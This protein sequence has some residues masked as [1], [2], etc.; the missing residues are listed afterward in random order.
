MSF[1]DFMSDFAQPE[2]KALAENVG[3]TF[4]AGH[5][6]VSVDYYGKIKNIEAIK[7]FLENIKEM[8]LYNRGWRFQFGTSKSWAGLCDA[9]EDQISKSKNKN[10]FIS[11]DFVKHDANWMKEMEGV[12][13]HEIAHAIVFEI[14]HF[15]KVSGIN[16]IDPEHNKTKGHG[17]IWSS[18]CGS[19]KG[20]EGG[21][22]RFYS[23]SNFKESFKNYKY[24]CFAC[25]HKEYGDFNNFA[26]K[27]SKCGKS[28]L[29]ENT[30]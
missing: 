9:S 14:F 7:P 15:G 25:G 4:D 21:C 26:V 22:S 18:I 30:I 5:E 10:I 13:L 2:K 12:I 6:L 29:T 17:K 24:D 8:N 16:L 23:D 28:V 3:E 27:C 20:S 19:I 11:I 1:D